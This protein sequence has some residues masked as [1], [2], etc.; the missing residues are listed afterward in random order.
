MDQQL[1]SE[2]KFVD[3]LAAEREGE[4]EEFTNKIEQLEEILKRKEKEEDSK[5][6]LGCVKV[7]ENTMILL[8]GYHINYGLDHSHTFHFSM[9][10]TSLQ[11]F[12]KNTWQINTDVIG[13]PQTAFPRTCDSCP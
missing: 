2:K 13:V 10:F 6:S 9:I 12:H 1:R 11:L 8:T 5:I 7:S 3:E 4:R